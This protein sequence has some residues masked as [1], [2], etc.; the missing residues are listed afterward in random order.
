VSI[1]PGGG[2]E[3]F[4]GKLETT[5]VMTFDPHWGSSVR[6]RSLAEREAMIYLAGE[7]AEGIRTG[8]R[9]RR[10]GIEYWRASAAVGDQSRSLDEVNAYVDWL[11]QRTKN[12]LQR[13]WACVEAVAAE[14]LEEKQMGSRKAHRI[15]K[16]AMSGA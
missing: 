16:E 9:A 10:H 7:I 3:A 12:V 13:Q 6:A 2:D 5:A 4:L 1:I 11:W 15:I 8:R 14:L